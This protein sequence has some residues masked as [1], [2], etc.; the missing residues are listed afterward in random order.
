MLWFGLPA[1]CVSGCQLLA[2]SWEAGCLEI[3][4]GSLE[5]YEQF[6]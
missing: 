2:D 6:R 1:Y 3:T 5:V 4:G